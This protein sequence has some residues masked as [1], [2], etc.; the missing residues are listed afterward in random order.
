M[1][2]RK[3]LLESIPERESFLQRA[4]DFQEAELAAARAKHAEKAR[5]GNRKAIESLE[6]VKA[7]AKTVRWPKGKRLGGY[8]A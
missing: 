8:E 4:F 2:R 3:Q 7:P 6:E 5:T 1:D